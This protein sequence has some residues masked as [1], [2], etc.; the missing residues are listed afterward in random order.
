M[1]LSTSRR[2][3]LSS[4]AVLILAGGLGVYFKD[5][6]QPA[7][8]SAQ[9]AAAPQA[10]PVSVA[11]VVSQDI[12]I[13]QEFSGRLEAVDSVE[14]R[15][16]VAGAVQSTEFAEGALVKKGDVLVT[17]DPAPFAA[18]VARAKAQLAATKAQVSYTKLELGRGQK[19]LGSAI[20]QSGL[21]QRQAAYDEAIA[22]EQAAA[23]ALDSANLD[24]GYTKI[25]AP[26]SGRVGQ[27]E[28]TPGN[29]VASG[30]T[31]PVLTTLVSVDPIYAS[32]DVDEHVVQQVLAAL[33]DTDAGQPD[34]SRV[35][36][37]I[38]LDGGA[39]PM[40]GHLQ[41]IDNQ[42]DAGTGTVHLRAIFD[43][44]KGALRPGQFVRVRLGQPKPQPQV[45]VSERAVGT[46]QDRKFVLLVGQDD[47]I[48]YRQVTLGDWVNGLRIVTAGLQ[49]GD[50]IVVDGLQRVRP[51][52]V[53]APQKVAMTS[54][55]GSALQD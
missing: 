7:P 46:D 5:L 8:A 29:L 37:Q 47:K 22:N 44:P 9:E 14:I 36:V 2:I 13:W 39:K 25:R 11:S 33:P 34:I 40:T 18:A 6:W 21:D 16:R 45:L 53:V 54:V 19:L 49:P 51:G 26:I 31:S 4:A 3:L 41:F 27:I 10:I 12:T 1:T 28:V 24:L 32:F 17:I 35:P 50:R 15:S 30:A 20:S 48:A 38:A 43:N 55:E 52:A 23:A 42:V